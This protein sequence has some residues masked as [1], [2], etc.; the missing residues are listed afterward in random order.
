MQHFQRVVRRFLCQTDLVEDNN[1]SIFKF[2]KFQGNSRSFGNH[3]SVCIVENLLDVARN[4]VFWTRNVESSDWLES[5]DIL[6]IGPPKVFHEQAK[7]KSFWASWLTD[8]QEGEPS[9]DSYEATVKVFF[10]GIVN[11]KRGVPDKIQPGAE[12]ILFSFFGSFDVSFL[13]TH[14]LF[15]E[16]LQLLS[17]P[18]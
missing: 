8:N 18:I 6:V 16:Q 4:S 14:L 17:S 10:K 1:K 2:V 13:E 9:V 15:N 5:L 12:V 11:G 3:W 7:G